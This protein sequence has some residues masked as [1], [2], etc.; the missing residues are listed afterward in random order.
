M[1]NEKHMETRK[2]IV[3]TPPLKLE[4]PNFSELWTYRD[5][6][7]LLTR[8]DLKV[9][10]QQTTVGFLWIIIQ[11]IIQM[12]IYY[13][14]LGVFAKVPTNGIPYPVFFLSGF[15][16]WQ[17]FSQI[18]NGSAFSLLSNVSIIIKSYFPRLSLPLS[19]VLSSFVD[20][21]INFIL[22]FLV[23][24]IAKYPITIRFLLIPI[25]LIVLTLFSSGVGLLFGALMVVFRDTK[26]LLAFILMI[27]MYLTPI[28]YPLSIVPEKYRSLFF[29]N[30]LTSIVE[31]FH[32]VFLNSGSLPSTTN[33]LI[34]SVI[35]VFIWFTGAIAFKSMEN[36]IADVM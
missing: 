12:L 25:L 11:P 15:I 34:S 18:V 8:R 20:F 36:K 33:L 24:I 14:I 10:F 23:I 29:I 19:L 21:L 13:L 28:I 31:S 4:L 3:I 5:L 26:N 2:P 6:I 27:W 35:A 9:R 1:K 30:P 32:W 22:L 16:V 7:T 17:Y